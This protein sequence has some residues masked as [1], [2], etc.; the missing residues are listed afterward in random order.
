VPSSVTIVLNDLLVAV[1][2]LIDLF[3]SEEGSAW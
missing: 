1:T 3:L 2:V